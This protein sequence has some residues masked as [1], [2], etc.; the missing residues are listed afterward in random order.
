MTAYVS[1]SRHSRVRWWQVRPD[2]GG[3]GWTATDGHSRKHFGPGLDL[4]AQAYCDARNGVATP[5]TQ[6]EEKL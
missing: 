5:P 3:D 4:E 2:A 1:L 6:P